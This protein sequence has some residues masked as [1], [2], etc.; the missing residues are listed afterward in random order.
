MSEVEC[1]SGAQGDHFS[2][3]LAQMPV[4]EPVDWSPRAPV[5]PV[6]LAGRTVRLE[7]LTTAHTD[8]L[9]QSL[10]ADSPPQLWTY[11]FSGP[12][13]DRAAF[14]EYVASV[15]GKPDMAAMAV[16][17]DGVALG[18]ACLMRC[19]PAHGVVEVGN[20]ALGARLQRTTAATEAMYLLA[21]HVFDDLGYRRYE[22]KC[23][24]LNEPSRRAALRL[25]FTYEGRF[26][27]AVVYKGRNRDTD[28]FSIIHAE[29]PV[30]RER[31]ESWLATDNFDE[32]G[33]QLRSLT[34]AARPLDG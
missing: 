22:W 20:I 33:G 4:G 7:P 27:N 17:V 25:G 3:Q 21:R 6:T 16:L 14:G 5:E 26:R 9:W 30:V 10:V 23:D 31:L 13:T 29:W 34:H 2:T 18:H 24:S 8:D 28:W 12:F 15:V 19:E 32:T 11:L 1:A